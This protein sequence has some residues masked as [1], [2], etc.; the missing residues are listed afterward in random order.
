[1][2]K[3]TSPSLSRLIKLKESC[4]LCSTSKI[5]CTKEKPS[6]K[7][8]DKSGFRCHYSPARRVGRPYRP[9]TAQSSI[10][11]SSESIHLTTSSE[12]IL[13]SKH[14][15]FNHPLASQE[16]YFGLL[17]NDK[18]AEQSL[19][20]FTG[21]SDNKVSI[22]SGCIQAGNSLNSTAAVCVAPT[23]DADC[24]LVGLNILENLISS[25]EGLNG[26]IRSCFTSVRTSL[27][28]AKKLICRILIC[29][30]SQNSDVLL[31]LTSIC[32]MMLDLIENLHQKIKIED[33]LD[34]ETGQ[35]SHELRNVA[36]LVLHLS[37]FYS[38]KED[39][40]VASPSPRLILSLR[41][42][43]HDTIDRT[44]SSSD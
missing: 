21:S 27:L 44:M 41:S 40:G 32:H 1:M 30:C 33:K 10:N 36:T 9:C 37:K 13:S 18:L 17:K 12:S 7:R 22:A 19:N 43:L 42:R 3:V 24:T 20:C 23:A 11:T 34:S 31:L 5:R 29:P 2:N 14:D 25:S 28:T 8:C 6:C 35:V 15:S 39:E 16:P 4:D 26:G 38:A